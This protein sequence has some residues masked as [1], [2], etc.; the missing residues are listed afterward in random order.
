M[1]EQGVEVQPTSYWRIRKQDFL[2]EESFQ[3]WDSY[4][5]ALAQTFFRFKDRLM[6]RS[7]DANEIGELRKQIIGAG[8]FVLTGQETRDHA[9][10]AIVLSYVAS[11]V[12]AILVVHLLT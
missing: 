3:S 10:P 2:P 8:I 4:F 7:D 5:S 12:S 9:G 11:G 6:S 1:G